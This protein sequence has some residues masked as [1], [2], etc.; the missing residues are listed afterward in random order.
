M[1]VHASYTGHRVNQT[2]IRQV[3]RDDDGPVGHYLDE[4][5]LLVLN[6][7]RTLVGVR[8][9][10]LLSTIR[11]ESGHGPFGPYRDITAG[12]RGLTNYLGYHH[13]GTESHII[14]ARRR[15]TLRFIWHGQVVYAKRVHHPG[16]KGTHFLTRALDAVR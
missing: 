11:R 3:F 12:R 5:S 8:T 15:K 6:R 16:T 9:G 14:T 7:A 10:L 4:L 1:A 2:G 13:D